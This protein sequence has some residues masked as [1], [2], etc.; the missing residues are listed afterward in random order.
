[1]ELL[2]LSSRLFAPKIVDPSVRSARFLLSFYSR[3]GVVGG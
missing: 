1:M 2:A 3:A